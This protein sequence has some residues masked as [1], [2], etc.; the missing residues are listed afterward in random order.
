MGCTV[1]GRSHSVSRKCNVV[2]KTNIFLGVMLIAMIQGQIK[3]INIAISKA[4]WSRTWF[5][6]NIQLTNNGFRFALLFMVDLIEILTSNVNVLR[7]ALLI[8][9]FS[10]WI[11]PKNYYLVT[12]K[13]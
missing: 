2:K 7:K 5:I 6:L 12:F 9:A 13:K 1:I 10:K 8:Y 3:T 4:L 11:C